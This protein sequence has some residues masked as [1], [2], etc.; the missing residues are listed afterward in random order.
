M[1]IGRVYQEN[2]TTAT[3]VI[4][5]LCVIAL[6][7]LAFSKGRK[8]DG[9][10]SKEAL[11]IE[12]DDDLASMPEVIKKQYSASKNLGIDDDSS[13]VA[14]FD[15]RH[16]ISNLIGNYLSPE[17]TTKRAKDFYKHLNRRRSTRFFDPDRKVP[18]E[19]IDNSL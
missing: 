2:K 7:Y 6:S 3:I 11:R 19:T 18:R 10:T 4:W 5:T 14:P 15:D 13:V 9:K 16:L 12:D 8:S 1:D 17:E